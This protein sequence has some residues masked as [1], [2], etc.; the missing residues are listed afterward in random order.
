MSHG[1]VVKGLYIGD[2]WTFRNKEF[3]QDLD[4]IVSLYDVYKRENVD[5]PKG[6]E[7]HLMEF[8]DIDYYLEYHTNW[9]EY[10]LEVYTVCRKVCDILSNCTKKNERILVH[11]QGGINRSSLVIGYYLMSQLGYSFESVCE[12]LA[13]TNNRYRNGCPYLM[14][15]FFCSILRELEAKGA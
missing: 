4:V 9:D 8:D 3:I 12:A 11:C 6:V 1:E 14:N 5:I 15:T 10:K 2:V 7:I 13:N